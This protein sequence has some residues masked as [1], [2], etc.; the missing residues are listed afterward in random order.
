MTRTASSVP[1]GARPLRAPYQCRPTSIVEHDRRKQQ[2]DIGPVPPAI[3]EQRGGDNSQRPASG[4]LYRAIEKKPA[5]GQGKNR[6]GCELNSTKK[7]CFAI[8]VSDVGSRGRRFEEL[9]QRDCKRHSNSQR[10]QGR[11]AGW[12]RLETPHNHPRGG[13]KGD[14]SGFGQGCIAGSAPSDCLDWPSLRGWRK[15]GIERD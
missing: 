10:G 8:G 12:V 7:S 13:I 1:A 15:R 6:N 11:A 9:S 2:A 5:R 14:C 3:E 4:R